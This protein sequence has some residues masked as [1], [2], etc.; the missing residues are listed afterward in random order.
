MTYVFTFI[1]IIVFVGYF[2]YFIKI[3]NKF[4]RLK[5]HIADEFLSEVDW[6]ESMEK[7]RKDFIDFFYNELDDDTRK[8]VPIETLWETISQKILIR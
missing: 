3:S 6:D 5:N 7:I 8:Q 2:I 1:C 4:D